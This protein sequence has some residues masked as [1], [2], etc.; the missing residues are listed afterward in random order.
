MNKKMKNKMNKKGFTL[1]ELLVVIAIIGLLTT[2][3][4]VAL[5]SARTKSRDAKRVTD[6]KQVQTALE[7]YFN[8]EDG[9]P[10]VDTQSTLGVDLACLDGAGFGTVVGDCDGSNPPLYMGQIPADIQPYAAAGTGYLYS[11][12]NALDTADCT[13][14]PCPIYEI[15]FFLEGD[16]GE[17]DGPGEFLATPDG[18]IKQ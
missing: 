18:I 17:L 4:V 14:A 15:T 8:D 10:A 16:A 5:D 7:L 9:Y 1:I 2:L 6:I 12:R 13:T 11:S 3:A